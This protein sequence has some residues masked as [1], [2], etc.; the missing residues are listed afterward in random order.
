[1]PSVNRPVKPSSALARSTSRRR[2]KCSRTGA[3]YTRRR[4]WRCA[5]TL[6]Q[7][8]LQTSQGLLGTPDGSLATGQAIALARIG[9]R[10]L[11]IVGGYGT[12]GSAGASGVIAVVDLSPLEATPQHQS[13]MVIAWVPLSHP[14]GDI[15]VMDNTVIV[16]APTGT[17]LSDDGIATLLN[18]ADPFHPTTAGSLT[19]VGSR[20]TVAAGI[21]VSTDR[22]IL[23]GSPDT[24]SPVRTASLAEAALITKV[25][26]DPIVV[27]ASGEVF[28]DVELD[29]RVLPW[30]PTMT[31]AEV[32]IGVVNGTQVANIPG[33][34]NDA[35][36]S[37]VW[38]KG[39][40]VNT[41]QSY[42]ATVHVLA[43]GHEV[44]PLP[45]RLH[46]DKIPLALTTR[47]RLLRIQFALPTQGLFTERKYGVKVYM[48]TPGGSYPADPAFALTSDQIQNAYP[49]ED[50]WWPADASSGLAESFVTRKID[51]MELPPG[52]DQSIHRQGFEI[53]TMLAGYPQ[54]KVVVISEDTKRELA[55]QEG[56]VT[57]D[58]DWS[59]ILT[60]IESRVQAAAGMPVADDPVPPPVTF[61]FAQKFTAASALIYRAAVSLFDF[62][63]KANIEV[64]K[65]IW[66]GFH[67]SLKG[68]G[69]FV[70]ETAHAL[71]N[72]KETARKA[73]ELWSKFKEELSKTSLIAMVKGVIAGIRSGALPPIDVED[74]L[75]K[76]SYY[77]GYLVGFVIEQ[78][79]VMLVVTALTFGA[80]LVV[81]AVA[82]SKVGIAA[83]G[84][85]TKIVRLLQWAASWFEA[86]AKLVTES[87][88]AAASIELFRTAGDLIE[89]FWVKYPQAT[90]LIAR[91]A[92][93]FATVGTDVATT[94]LK[95]LTILNRVSDAIAER[96]IVFAERKG[97]QLTEQW[98][99]RW[100]TSG[101]LRNGKQAVGEAFDAYEDSAA[102]DDWARD[103]LVSA[104]DAVNTSDTNFVKRWADRYRSTTDGDRVPS[105][106]QR[107]RQSAD[108]VRYSDGTIGTTFKRL[109]DPS[110]PLLSDRS[111]EG[112]FASIIG[113]CR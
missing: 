33:P 19:G 68:D 7:G 111:V 92:K 113:E 25:L 60:R 105:I 50:Q 58:D 22:T 108:D 17:A 87:K 11:A 43:D 47:D 67:G 15:A 13:P 3:A 37:V 2:P 82:A 93:T 24:T 103:A 91:I 51:T 77:V 65:G 94:A 107:A 6:W 89:A 79:L 109:G 36:G 59:A 45:R 61:D 83:I 106:L 85:A 81:R 88:F 55:I 10:D 100:V 99:T 28:T 49:N 42:Q 62:E 70:V 46:L 56:V 32:H 27:S 48:T 14:V 44:R 40:I 74:M 16:S 39:T 97:S 86:L 96:I 90:D 110:A 18:L 63:V 1:M 41:A 23:A 84:L 78:V 8:A 21:L 66:D 38:P 72:P 29:Y 80:G 95:W 12:V 26:P 4:P 76:G 20:V 64:I 35:V 57:E 9:D 101:R 98:M 52:T 5:Q 31:T 102:V 104:A 54:V 71:A 75:L 53:G 30:E 112:A 34:L 69:Q 73:A